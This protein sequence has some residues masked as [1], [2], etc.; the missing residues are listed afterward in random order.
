LR[1]K[2]SVCFGI[3]EAKPNKFGLDLGVLLGG[4]LGFRERLASQL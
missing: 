3:E 4:K 2:L 1:A